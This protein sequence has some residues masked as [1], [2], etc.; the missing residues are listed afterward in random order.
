[1][2][3]VLL[4]NKIYF[5]VL[6]LFC[7]IPEAHTHTQ[8]Y[9][10]MLATW[11]AAWQN[12]SLR[13][14]SFSEGKTIIRLFGSKKGGLLGLNKAVNESDHELLQRGF[15]GRP[16]G[17]RTV[18]EGQPSR[19]QAWENWPGRLGM[20]REVAWQPCSCE[21]GPGL[22][23]FNTKKTGPLKL[24]ETSGWRQGSPLKS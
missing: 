14:N 9:F 23:A 13:G 16:K 17:K 4:F 10:K 5:A 7:S 18:G 8:S 2:Y 1:M 22:F 11:K 24:E 20:T 12:V 3:L 15:W 21:L 19:W 6:Y